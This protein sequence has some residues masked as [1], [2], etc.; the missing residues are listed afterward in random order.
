MALHHSALDLF[1]KR[2]KPFLFLLYC[3]SLVLRERSV[4]RQ[5]DLKNVNNPPPREIRKFIIVA[6]AWTFQMSSRRFLDEIIKER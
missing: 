6:G 3:I 4:T 5:P 1:K 2:K